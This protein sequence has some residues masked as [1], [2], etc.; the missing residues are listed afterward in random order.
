MKTKRIHFTWRHTGK[1]DYVTIEVDKP[2]LN[3]KEIKKGLENEMS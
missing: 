3:I 2:M 1:R